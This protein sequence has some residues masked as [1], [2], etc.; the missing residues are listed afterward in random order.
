MRALFLLVTLT[1]LAFGKVAPSFKGETLDGKR[2][3]LASSLAAGKPL[4]LCF[5]AT[6]CTPCLEE[7]KNVKEKMKADPT[8][9]L[10]LLTVNVDTSETSSDVSSTLR[11]YDF[12][13]PVIQDANH[14]IFGL[15]QPSKTLPFSALITPQGD[16]ATTFSGYDP[17]MFTQVKKLTSK[18]QK[19]ETNAKP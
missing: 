17:E 2:V 1:T 14:D 18:T 4:L 15:Y 16:I 9:A 7:L 13:F 8:L 12:K 3:S 10:Q 5:W 19:K 6:W 11:L